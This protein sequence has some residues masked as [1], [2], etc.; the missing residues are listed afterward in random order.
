MRVLVP[1]L[2][3]GRPG[4]GHERAQPLRAAV[5]G[6]G[7]PGR[8][9]AEH[10]EIEALAVDLGAQAR[11]SARPAPRTGCASPRWRAPAPASPSAGCR[12]TRAA[13]A[14]SASVSTSYQRTGSRLRSSRS[15]TSNARR[16]PR[17]AIRRMTPCPSAS[18]HA[19]RASNV[20]EHVLAE[21]RP[22]RDHV[23]QSRPVEL[24]HVRRLDGDAGAD[25]RLSGERGDVADERAAV[26]LRDID[27]LA[28]LAVDELDEPALDDVERRIADGV[29]VEHLAGLERAPLPALGQPRE[30]GVGEP[31]EE[32]LVAE[33]GERLTANDLGRCHPWELP[34]ASLGAQDSRTRAV[35]R[36][37]TSRVLQLDVERLETL[38]FEQPGE[39]A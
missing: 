22:A 4:L 25:R 34:R 2:P 30:L 38:S 5:H 9:R 31:R 7:Q 14:L 23:A 33:I 3:A 21:L 17:G 12:A 26:C 8:S 18:C 24:D 15:R 1:G 6:G 32:D 29:L 27:V 36:T 19:R 39:Q 11:A 16:E 37:R 28:G 10:D 20:R 35:E 13:A